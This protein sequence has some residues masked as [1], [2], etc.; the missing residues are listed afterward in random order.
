MRGMLGEYRA[1]AYDDKAVRDVCYNCN[2]PV[3]KQSYN[4]FRRLLFQSGDKVWSKVWYDGATPVAFYFASRCRAHC[5]LIEI[6]VRQ[7]YKGKGVGKAALF[8]LLT[9]MKQSGLYKLTFRT[10][11]GED[12]QNFWLHVGAKIID[13]KG[14][15]YEMELTIK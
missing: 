9:R 10:P 11:I 4:Y 2:S 7:E 5:R 8:D 3:A 12:A 14:N 6:A 15:D 13:V 1:T